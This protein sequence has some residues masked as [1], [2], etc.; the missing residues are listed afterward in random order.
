LIRTALVAV[1]VKHP[2]V[3][4][5]YSYMIP[6]SLA[7]SISIGDMVSVPFNNTIVLGVVTELSD[8]TQAPSDYKLKEIISR[9]AVTL[10]GCLMQLAR[11]LAD[12]Y[13][14][15]VIDFLKLMLP[16]K[17]SEKREIIYT[18]CGIEGNIS[19]RAIVQRQVYD[20]IAKNGGATLQEVSEKLKIPIASVKSALTALSKKGIVKKEYRAVR[21]EPMTLSRENS[22]S[23]F[24]LTQEQRKAVETLTNIFSSTKKTTLVYGV[25]GSGKT[26]V[27]IRTIQ[28]V[29]SQGKSA[30]LL[31]PEISLTPQMLSIFRSRFP[32]K[33]A[34]VHSRLSAGERFD[35][36]QKIN[37]GC[38]TVVIGAR[39]A[40]FAPIQNL[41]LIIIDEEHETSYKNGEYP[42]YD[43]KLVAEFRA[44]HENAMIVLGSATPSVESYY[45]AAIGEY[46]LVK[47]TRR[48][49]GR[50]LPKLEIIDMKSE[51]EAGNRHIFSRKLLAGIKATLDA[52]KQ[53]ILFL[54]RRGHSTFVICRDCGFVLKC[55][56]CDISLTYHYND[57]TAK[58]H[59][60]G[61]TVKAPDICPQCRSK[62]I[63]FFGAGTEKV[64]QEIKRFFPDCKTVRIDS[65]STSKKGSLEKML[66]GFKRGDAQILIGTQ[67]VAKG[68]DFPNV[69]LVGIVSADTALNMPDFRC[70]ERTF[71]LITQVAGRAGRGDTPGRVYVQTYAPE[72]FAIK[73]ACSLD[74]S[75][76]YKDEL[77]MRYKALYPPFCHMLNIRVKGPNEEEVRQSAEDVKKMLCENYNQGVTIYGPVPAPRS[78]IKENYRYNILIKS[79]QIQLL[80]DICNRM[81]NISK[82]RS[83]EIAWDLEPLDLL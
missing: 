2:T 11:T 64:E 78:R 68:L 41:G 72:A 43:A 1:D 14:T 30:L 40:I 20:Y 17:T 26:E 34:V 57:K 32:G 52:N 36:W 83:V 74:I 33:T 56:Y 35:E 37:S 82:N 65:D 28:E 42:Y 49:S 31:V 7:S 13:G 24:S 29:I 63:R 47:L 9:E 66:L 79:K 59:Y 54:N 5:E 61:Y 8:L 27:Y 25:T 51:L 6:E 81:Q 60:C 44:K 67:A 46:A 45:K 62:N 19:E 76:F 77:K 70:G 50:P 58:C 22:K 73:A 71:Q 69:A 18:L 4:K 38:A 80:S 10:P 16:P 12:F 15:A 39:S 48:V 3:K 55:K 75:G 21:R 53:I 23:Y